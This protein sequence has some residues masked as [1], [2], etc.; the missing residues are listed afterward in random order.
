L[1]W[2]MYVP[3]G[4]TGYYNIQET[5]VPGVAWNLELLF[6]LSGVGVPSSSGEGTISIPLGTGDFTY[7]VDEWFK[8]EH[9]IDLD[10]NTIEIYVD[11]VFVGSADYTGNIGSVDFYSI[12]ANCKSYFDDIL[13]TDV[14]NVTYQVDVT[15]Y[16]AEGATIS[17]EGMRVGGNFTDLGS[18][19]PNW[20]PSDPASAMTDIGG[21]IWEITVQYPLGS[22]GMTLEYKYVNG[23]WFPT[24][25]N[26][27]DDGAASMF[28]ELGCGGENREV[29]VPS[30]DATYLYCWEE[31]SACE[32]TETCVAVP[33]TDL[34]VDE[35]N[36]FGG[37]IHWT[38]APGTPVTKGTIWELSTGEYRKFT[39]YDEDSYHTPG[40]L[41][42][43]T[44]Y[45]V[46]VKSGC[47]D[48]EVWTPSEFTDWYYFTTDPLRVGQFAQQIMLYPN[49]NNGSFR[50]QVN[51]SANYETSVEVFNM[52]GQLMTSE[53]IH[54][55][56]AV[57]TLDIT[58]E[59]A[60]PGNY[61]VKVV[62]GENI[63]MLPVIIE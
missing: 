12:D 54:S 32:T 33:P 38:I 4:K 60:T 48:G 58:M 13:F 26:E 62:S 50:L 9:L 27:Y 25:E 42:P 31:C 17:A 40:E 56:D 55:D 8:V 61:I 34:Y 11:G 57:I 22:A 41:L 2:M 24:G 7:P 23:D 45:G 10:G 46:R 47:L 36:A 43:S 29:T 39:L 21:N 59:N 19:I 52:A 35:I 63:T 28:G 51:G 3:D 37:M 15:N 16:I 18:S 30:S 14:I 1:E 53:I 44:T 20:T 49:P 6:G 5:E